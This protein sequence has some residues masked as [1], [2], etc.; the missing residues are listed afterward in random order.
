M[1]EAI[2]RV[3]VVDDE[4]DFRENM[5]KLLS[6]HKNL[7]ASAAAS[8]EEAIERLAAEPADVVLLDVKMPG[9]GAPGTLRAMKEM[10]CPAVAVILTGHAS[11][12]DA[13]ELMNLG[14][15][16]YLLKPCPTKEIVKKITW[17]YESKNA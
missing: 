6:L 12:D 9:M 17:A 5:L 10:G 16:D 3:L 8:G 15:F 1:S 14:A 2:I 7:A 13:V 4:P 11:V